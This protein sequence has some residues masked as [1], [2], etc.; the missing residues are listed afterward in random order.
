ML[1]DFQS[2]GFAKASISEWKL[3][4]LVFVGHY[5]N[6]AVNRNAR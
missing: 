6:V 4:R 1:D 5:A 3:T 2:C